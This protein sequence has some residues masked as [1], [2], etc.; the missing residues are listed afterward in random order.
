[1]GALADPRFVPDARLLPRISHAHM[2]ELATRGAGFAPQSVELA[3]QFGVPLWVLNSFNKNEGTFVTEK[4]M[5]ECA[6]AGVTAGKD[7]CFIRVNL[8]GATVL[9][10]LWDNAAQVIVSIVA[11]VFS[12]G[13]VQFFA[14][15]DAQGDWKKL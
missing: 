5:E 8:T 3:K 13:K 10:A 12:E 11:P 9:G 4:G 6:C 2:V 7:K 1:M 15:A 14:D